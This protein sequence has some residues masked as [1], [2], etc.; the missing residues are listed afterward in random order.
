MRDTKGLLYIGPLTKLRYIET[1][2]PYTA[3]WNEILKLRDATFIRK[4]YNES[5]IEKVNYVK[6]CIIQAHEYFEASRNMSLH[7]KPLL[8]YY[9]ILNLS[10][11]FIVLETKQMPKKHHGLGNVKYSNNLVNMKADYKYGIFGQLSGMLNINFDKHTFTLKDF[12][13]SNVDLYFD[14]INMY[15]IRKSFL[16]PSI[17]LYTRGDLDIE[18]H[19][20]SDI[21]KEKVSSCFAKENDFVLTENTDTKLIYSF[22]EKIEGIEFEQ[23]ADSA[24][25]ILKRY[26]DYSILGSEYSFLKIEEP[27]YPMP[28]IISYFGILFF[29]S[30]L[31]RYEPH[32]LDMFLNGKDNSEYWFLNKLCEVS[33][34]T[35]ASVF[36]NAMYGEDIVFKNF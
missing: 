1:H 24:R 22:K 29:L 10:K 6:T 35:I 20:L 25:I 5:D 4:Q 3:S 18:F 2:N 31:V 17:K 30:N 15:D 36:M 28:K 11:A 8:L 14:A 32:K 27:F 9:C 13:M 19:Q 33:E 21:E 7:T 16:V 23:K 12:I 34:R 26:F